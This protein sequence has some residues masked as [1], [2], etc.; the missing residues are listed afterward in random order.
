MDLRDLRLADLIHATRK[1]AIVALCSGTTFA[2]CASLVERNTI[3]PVAGVLV[4]CGSA[5]GVWIAALVAM[6]HPL[7]PEL[8]APLARVFYAASRLVG[9]VPVPAAR[10]DRDVC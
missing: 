9:H 3:G 2:I 6:Q 5:A 10:T 1:S 8:K 7:L 4:A